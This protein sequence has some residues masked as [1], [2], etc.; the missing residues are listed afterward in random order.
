MGTRTAIFQEQT[1]GEFLGIYVHYDG[2]IEGV[3]ETLFEHYK[4][5]DK[6]YELLDK[7]LALGSL[8][9]TSII[10][11]DEDY[12]ELH[13]TNPEE[14]IK[15]C[16]GGHISEFF[17]AESLDEI[18]KFDYLVYSE[19]QIDGFYVKG[20][21]GE[22]EFIPYRGSDNNGFLY[23]QDL[24]GEWFVSQMEDKAPYNMKEF[25]KL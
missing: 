20:E 9:Q 18:R 16:S 14:T 6:T 12:R 19:G 23:Y 22:D 11:N 4:S 2:Y 21:N 7:K 8:G 3:G 25:E 1:N 17:L 15:Y 5:R 13:R 10:L 24:K